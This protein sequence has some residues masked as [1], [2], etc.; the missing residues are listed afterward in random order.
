MATYITTTTFMH[1]NILFV[2]GILI[3][4]LVLTFT[5]IHQCLYI[6]NVK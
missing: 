2:D 4:I 5:V 1:A 3:F 6:V